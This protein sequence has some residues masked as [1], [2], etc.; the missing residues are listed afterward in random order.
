MVSC[1]NE[2]P[3]LSPETRYNI[4]FTTPCCAYGLFCSVLKHLILLHINILASLPSV[5]SLI[6][7]YSRDQSKTGCLILFQLQVLRSRVLAVQAL[8]GMDLLVKET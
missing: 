8:L 1:E 4:P 5:V 3:P 7:T 6:E 2:V